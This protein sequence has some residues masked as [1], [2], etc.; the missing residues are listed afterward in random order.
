MS[1]PN[2]IKCEKLVRLIGTPVAP[3]IIDVR[4]QEDFEADPCLIPG[5]LKRSHQS[6]S[7]W[8]RDLG[9]KSAVAVCHH[10]AKLSEGT[11]AWLRQ[12]GAD[13]IS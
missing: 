2:S 11:A 7:E 13:A 5:S 9:G 8:G 12:L 4:T 3:V 6:V 10:G 1:A